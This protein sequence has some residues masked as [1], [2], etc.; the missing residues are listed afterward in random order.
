M[1][2]V[3]SARCPFVYIKYHLLFGIWVWDHTIY[4]NYIMLGVYFAIQNPQRGTV[5]CITV[6]QWLGFYSDNRKYCSRGRMGAVRI[7]HKCGLHTLCQ[8]LDP[9]P[10]SSVKL[11]SVCKCQQRYILFVWLLLCSSIIYILICYTA[12]SCI[13]CKHVML[14]SVW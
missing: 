6:C 5:I 11:E 7:L 14:W 10:V 3:L 13:V 9:R 12:A 8:I 4:N 2:S 1:R